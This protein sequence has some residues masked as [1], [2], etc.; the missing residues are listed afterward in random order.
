MKYRVKTKIVNAVKKPERTDF[1]TP[2]TPPNVEINRVPSDV[3][4]LNLSCRVS[5]RPY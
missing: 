1:P 5:I 3:T 2:I 4:D